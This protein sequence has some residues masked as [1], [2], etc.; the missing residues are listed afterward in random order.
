MPGSPIATQNLI[1]SDSIRFLLSAVLKWVYSFVVFGFMLL[2]NE[3]AKA[4]EMG[5]STRTLAPSV[6]PVLIIGVT[7]V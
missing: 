4:G 6:P 2:R 3:E 1:S 5:H 7:C